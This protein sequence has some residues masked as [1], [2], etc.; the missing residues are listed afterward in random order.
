MYASIIDPKIARPL[1]D[2]GG[3]SGSLFG[4][5]L[6]VAAILAGAISS[7]SSGDEPVPPEASDAPAAE[8]AAMP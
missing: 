2:D 5:F 8:V 4:A 6:L 1:N 7:G 3:G